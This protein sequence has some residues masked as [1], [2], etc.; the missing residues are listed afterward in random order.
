MQEL[1]V[2][3][4]RI[5]R[6]VRAFQSRKLRMRRELLG[7]LQAALDEERGHGADEPTA[8]EQA[9]RRLGDPSDVTR[10]LQKSVSLPE[11]ILLAKVPVSKKLENLEVRTGRVWGLNG[12]MTMAHTALLIATALVMSMISTSLAAKPLVVD[13]SAFS[14]DAP[15]WGN[16]GLIL[17]AWIAE[18]LLVML[19]CVFAIATSR[20]NTESPRSR[21]R[22]TILASIIF[23]L[24]ILWMVLICTVFGGGKSLTLRDWISGL[25]V[26]AVTLLFLILFGRFMAKLRRPY[27]A[28]LALDV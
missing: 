21:R 2:H 4:E 8:I 11:R 7:H 23:P 10:E 24:H 13:R 16:K 9:K 20:P 15:F 14:T 17:L 12:R 18:N 26:C 27:D 5:V 28:W 1:M 22:A 25:G 6:P 19:Y 3:V